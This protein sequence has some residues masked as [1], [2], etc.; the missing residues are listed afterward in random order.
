MS[1]WSYDVPW[2]PNFE[3]IEVGAWVG[4]MIATA[5]L[6]MMSSQLPFMPFACTLGIQAAFAAKRL[7]KAI[8]LHRIKQRLGAQPVAMMSQ[9]KLVDFMMANPTSVYLGQGYQWTQSEG[10]ML[11]DLLKRDVTRFVP[12]AQAGFMGASWI[13]GLTQKKDEALTLETRLTSLHELIVGTTGSGKTRLFDLKI[14]QAVLRGEAVIVIDPKGDRELAANTRRA[15]EMAGEPHR[16][17]YFHPA[18]PEVSTRISPTRNFSRP[19]EVASRIAA[20]MKSEPGNPF[21]AFAMMAINNVVQALLICGEQPTL[22]AIRRALEGAIAPLIVKA[23]HAYSQPVIP[24]VE[25]MIRHYAKGAQTDESKAHALIAMYRAEVQPIKADSDLEGILSM[26]EHDSQHF[27]KM[28]ASLMPVLNMLTSGHMGPLLSPQDDDSDEREVTDTK[29][30]IDGG[31]VLYLGLDALSDPLVGS[32]IGSIFLADLASVAGERYNYGVSLRPVSIFVDEAAEVVND[33]LIQLLNKG[34]GAQLSLYVATQTIADF[35]ARMGDAA[36]ARQVLGNTNH[37]IALRITDPDT[38]EFVASKIPP[39]RFKYIMRTQGATSGLDPHMHSGN[40]GE[41]LME[42]EGELF[43]SR[44]FGQLPDLE[45]IAIM[46]GGHLIKGKVPVLTLAQD[47]EKAARKV[48]K[49]KEV[50]GK[51]AA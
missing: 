39:T 14:S 1:E 22:V 23:V 16:F 10:Q 36:K 20:L 21:Q 26:F 6:G 17:K 28:I 31:Q 35:E 27:A 3:A 7:P 40:V 13:H 38:Q 30:I 34:R 45:Y 43:P 19:T 32:A 51:N 37:L 41:R 18:F 9:D 49:Y 33:Q 46:A 8:Q 5:S 11:F 2:R 25:A 12:K 24:D 50:V 47:M 44:M 4:G 29:K 42:E 48:A 15:C